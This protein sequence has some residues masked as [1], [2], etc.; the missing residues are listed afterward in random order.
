[1]SDESIHQRLR[2]AREARAES[3]DALARRVG[4]RIE[5]VAAIEEGRFHALPAGIYARAAI[6]AYARA[7]ALDPEST[8]V[9]CA[10]L[11]PGV[12]DPIVA[13]NRLRGISVSDRRVEAFRFHGIRVDHVPPPGENQG[14]KPTI[15]G[16]PGWRDAAASAVDAIV[17]AAMLIAAITG[18]VAVGVPISAL[19]G[20]G[21]AFFALSI[22]LGACYFIVFGGL[23]GRTVGEQVIGFSRQGTNPRALDARAVLARTSDSI[24]RESYCIERAG[25]WIGRITIT[26]WH[27]P[28]SSRVA[29]R[30]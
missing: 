15:A 18:T 11:L 5:S 30:D 13:L 23:V 16:W 21:T 9:E 3:R 12:D 22:V 19:Q 14:G 4:L 29:V 2:Q 26:D 6:R 17:I 7:V 25:E 27:W 8:L 28:G 20:A 1:M 24:L 10:P